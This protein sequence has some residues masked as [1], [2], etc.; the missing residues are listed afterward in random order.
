MSETRTLPGYA[1]WHPADGI[2]WHKASVRIPQLTH[3][4]REAGWRIIPVTITVTA[5]VP[6]PAATET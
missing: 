2:Q 4:E 3:A 6:E 1:V 5:P